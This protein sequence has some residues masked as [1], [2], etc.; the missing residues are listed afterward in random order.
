MIKKIH[1]WICRKIEE[2]APDKY[3]GI[4]RKKVQA[5]EKVYYA[6][7]DTSEKVTICCLGGFELLKNKEPD[8]RDISTKG[9]FLIGYIRDSSSY[10]NIPDSLD[11]VCL[12]EKATAYVNKEDSR[13]VSIDSYKCFECKG[14]KIGVLNYSSDTDFEVLLQTISIVKQQKVKYI[15][16]YISYDDLDN[17]AINLM[18]RILNHTNQV[19]GI[20]GNKAFTLNKTPRKI[21]IS[22][23]SV[24]TE[25]KND[26]NIAFPVLK[27]VVKMHDDKIVITEKSY[28]PCVFDY[29]RY[30]IDVIYPHDRKYVELRRDLSSRILKRYEEYRT[31]NVG[32]IFELLDISMDEKYVKYSDIPVN[33]MCVYPSELIRKS[34]L[35]LREY[36]P[37]VHEYEEEEYYRRCLGTIRAKIDQGLIFIFSP[38]ELPEDIPHVQV[39]SPL[40]LHRHICSY[41]IDQFDFDVKV[42]VTG[43]T[44]KT[45]AKEMIA[46]VLSKKYKTFKNNGNENLQTK[47][48]KLLQELSPQYSA[49]VQEVGGGKINGASNFSKM[50]QPDIGVVTNIGYSHLR[51][52]KTR[53]QLAINKMGIGDGI[54]NN[55]PVFINI[56]NDMLQQVDTTGRNIITYGIENPSAD[57]N[58][59][60]IKES[61]NS[62]EFEIEHEGNSYELFLNV[63][64]KY[65]IYN[66]L[67]SFGIGQYTGIPYEK[68]KEGI[69][70]FK[71]KG[72]RQTL[73]DVG[74]YKLFVDCYNAAPDSMC[75]AVEAISNMGDKS[76][77]RIAVLADMTGLDELSVSLHE[78]VGRKISKYDI[79]YLICYGEDSKYIFECCQNEN[80]KKYH[81]TEKQDVLD[82]LKQIMKP[83]DVL[84]FKGSSK[85]KL[86]KDIV[87]VLFGTNLSIEAYRRSKKRFYRLGG[88]RYRLYPDFA[89]VTKAYYDSEDKSMFDSIG[90]RNVVSILMNAFVNNVNLE[91][92]TLSANLR[93]IQNNA[94]RGC[95]NLKEIV[96]CS[97]LKVIGSNAFRGCS[98]LVTI[99][100]KEGLMHIGNNA[101]KGCSELKQIKL[102]SS[103]SHIGESAF[104]G[105]DDLTIVAGRDTYAAEYATTN[106]INLVYSD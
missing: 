94:F 38:I 77:K 90:S 30:S 100:F 6:D 83:N 8:I 43:S 62:I 64:G 44:G 60:N 26:Q 9:D 37:V 70:E 16:V 93:S 63:P 46:L 50:L 97:E 95:I 45:S 53:E 23:G 36:D 74:G 5:Y 19:V 25:V 88:I 91:R 35:F 12:S 99:D 67:I 3:E 18:K 40:A 29:E 80:L 7:H 13:L 104:E 81:F 2:Y 75:G 4:K 41:I 48:A 87:D 86:E 85:F 105:C 32:R 42:A 55:G 61:D 14:L 58:A 57:Y 10:S 65:N 21:M 1:K 101:F 71:T 20:G 106:N 82:T 79:D 28:I 39:E 78:E 98:S 73:F 96:F 51:W 49:Y 27:N 68:I 15:L 102:P 72:I 89:C 31:L 103:L 22:M 76:S 56:D 59:V 34:V 66:A 47:L 84:L 24:V 17:K 54:R 52:S 11:A 33:K 92:I 69:A